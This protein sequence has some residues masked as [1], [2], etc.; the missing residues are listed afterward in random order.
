MAACMAAAAAAAANL[1]PSEELK[2]P[3]ANWKIRHSRNH[4]WS[5]PTTDP[6]GGGQKGSCRSIGG[7]RVGRPTIC[8]Q[9]GR[10]SL[11][12]RSQHIL[13]RPIPPTAPPSPDT[14]RIRSPTPAQRR[15]SGP[16]STRARSSAQPTRGCR[17]DHD[18][19]DGVHP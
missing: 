2:V 7:P 5:S 18:A 1:N 10:L 19:N 14:S 6:D 4:A 17:F 9:I 3:A 15:S 8:C 16:V 11:G 12:M 13:C